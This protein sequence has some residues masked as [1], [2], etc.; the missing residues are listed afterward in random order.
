RRGRATVS[1]PSRPPRPD[2][3]AAAAARVRGTAA[4]EC[5]RRPWGR[6]RPA[7]PCSTAAS[8]RGRRGLRLGSRPTTLMAV[9]LLAI[10]YL[11]TTGYY[12][13]A[14]EILDI[15]V[16]ELFCWGGMAVS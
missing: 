8:G 15:E 2:G 6:R 7:V 12:R 9:G 4:A 5:Q 14:P 3:S 11:K 13:V 10:N 1:R 16:C